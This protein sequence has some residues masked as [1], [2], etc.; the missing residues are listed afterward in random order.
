MK[1]KGS[2]MLVAVFLAAMFPLGGMVRAQEPQQ[3]TSSQPAQA[4]AQQ[5]KANQDVQ[6]FSGK[7]IKSDGK[8][9]LQDEAAS[10]PPPIPYVLD[11]QEAAKKYK[12]KSV[13]VRGTLDSSHNTIHV[14]KITVG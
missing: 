14:T 2:T 11:D 1:T 4:T 6:V 10:V 9:V 5:A 13:A 7:I 8:W 3:A 12:G